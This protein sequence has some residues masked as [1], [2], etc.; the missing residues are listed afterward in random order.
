MKN[1]TTKTLLKTLLYLFFIVLATM[2]IYPLIWIIINS[3]K[4]NSELFSNSLSLPKNPMWSNYVKAWK[5]GLSTYF[6]NSLF[7]GAISVTAT[8]F[9]GAACAY[10]IVRSQ[11]KFKNIVFYMILG[12][13][14]LSPQVALIS[15]YKIIDKIGLYNTYWAMIIPYIAFKLPFAVFLMRSYFLGFPKE[16]EES[17]YIDGCGSIQTFFRIVLP[18]SKPILASTAIMTAIFVWNEFLFALVFIEDKMKMT[19]PV[20][21]S[22][23]RD[24]LVTDWTV[25][26]AG[27]VIGSLPMIIFF[28]IMQKNFIKG[29]TAGGIKG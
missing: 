12:G 15:L 4:T 9:L 16:L 20:G 5:L 7:V 23:F 21:L 1:K 8:V 22:N 28:L 11:S 3:L 2:V 14:L 25:M 29:L 18:I 6:L 10:G 17:A 13:L 24:A 27:I 26:L 19:I